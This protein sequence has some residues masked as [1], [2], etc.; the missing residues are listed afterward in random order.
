MT[1]TKS[2]TAHQHSIHQH[3]MANWA[4]DKS[5]PSIMDILGKVLSLKVTNHD[6]GHSD[7]L[8]RHD[9]PPCLNVLYL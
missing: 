6:I 7:F 9:T 4:I 8:L 1:I 2:A 3:S 5:C